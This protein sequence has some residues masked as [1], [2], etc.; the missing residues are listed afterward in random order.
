MMNQHSTRVAIILTLALLAFASLLPITR[1]QA[2]RG[3]AGLANPGADAVEGIVQHGFFEVAVRFYAQPGRD[4][5]VLAMIPP[6]TPLSVT[7]TGLPEDKGYG[8]VRF[9]ETDGFISLLNLLPMPREIPDERAGK[10]MFAPDVRVLREQSLH[11]AATLR[12]LLPETPLMVLSRTKYMLKVQVG[13]QEGYVYGGNLAELQM[14]TTLEPVL[15]YSAEEQ[16]L[17]SYPL[18]GSEALAN[19]GAGQLVSVIGRN[20]HYLKVRVNDQEGYIPQEKAGQI[21]ALGE[22]AMLVYAMQAL[23]LLS[24][25][26]STQASGSVMEAREAVKASGTRTAAVFLRFSLRAQKMKAAT[27]PK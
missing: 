19:L 5:K 1:G 13:G 6:F 23:P 2:E 20:R 7:V 21:G 4:Q 22:D 10:T 15:M 24:G 3:S 16:A 12:R 8:R 17:F 26:D 11:N 25:P 14:D 18:S 27:M 9:G